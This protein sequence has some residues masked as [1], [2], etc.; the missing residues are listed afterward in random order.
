MGGE[1]G[2]WEE[3]ALHQGL[4]WQITSY[5]THRGVQKMVK[6]LNH[7]YLKKK[8]LWEFD[9]DPRGFEWVDFHDQINSVL[10]YLRKSSNSCLLCVHHF[11]PEF[12]PNYYIKLTNIRSIKEVFNSDSTEYN[13]SGKL[14]LHPKVV[15]KEGIEIQLAPLATM[16]FEVEFYY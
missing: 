8:E 2:V 12:F 9:F 7:L 14:N 3:W 10:S 6:E 4:P 1:I 5:P 15:E 11:T 13:G 16:I